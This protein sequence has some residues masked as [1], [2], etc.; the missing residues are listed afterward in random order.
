MTQKP[1][2]CFQPNIHSYY[3]ISLYILQLPN[4]KTQMKLKNYALGSWIEGD[5]D[6][7]TKWTAA[8]YNDCKNFYIATWR[9][10]TSHPKLAMAK[11]NKQVQADDPSFLYYLLRNYARPA[12]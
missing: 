10:I 1:K 9:L 12:S 4:K 7:N 11:Y 5:G 2:I 8:Q 3:E 6:G